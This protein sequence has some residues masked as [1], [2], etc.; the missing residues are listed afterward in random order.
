[1]QA[2][3]LVNWAQYTFVI[4]WQKSNEFMSLPVCSSMYDPVWSS[5]SSTLVPG[6][7]G[8]FTLHMC[9]KMTLPLN[10]V[11]KIYYGRLI[12]WVLAKLSSLIGQL[13]MVHISV[14][15]KIENGPK[16]NTKI[17][18]FLKIDRRQIRRI[19]VKSKILWRS[20][21]IANSSNIFEEFLN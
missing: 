3:S 10:I 14:A 19:F 5:Q 8:V 7:W 20:S 1:M 18:W 21:K 13:A 15:T 11:L 12:N 16:T 4:G 9:L 2:L 17:L 6:N